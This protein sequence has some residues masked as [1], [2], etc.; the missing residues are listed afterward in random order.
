MDSNLVDNYTV[1]TIH[2]ITKYNHMLSMTYASCTCNM[3]SGAQV[4]QPVIEVSVSCAVPS[5]R[6]SALQLSFL[7]SSLERCVTPCM[8][9]SAAVLE[10][11][12]STMHVTIVKAC[13]ASTRLHPM[14]VSRTG[15]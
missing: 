12:K 11:S 14:A 2:S 3:P 9:A 15:T 10:G 1:H 5:D 13:P 4:S 8:R 6:Y 7:T